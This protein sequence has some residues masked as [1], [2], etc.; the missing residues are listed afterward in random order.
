MADCTLVTA[1]RVLSGLVS[2]PQ[3]WHNSVVR[4]SLTRKVGK[5]LAKA[6]AM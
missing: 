2:A 3:T 1:S 4:N 6:L 5:R